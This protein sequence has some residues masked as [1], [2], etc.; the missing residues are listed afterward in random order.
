MEWSG[1]NLNTKALCTLS[2]K[3]QQTPQDSFKILQCMLTSFFME[4]IA[5][6]SWNGV[7]II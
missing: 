4:L 2:S 5:G 7:V 6:K 1:N 3:Q